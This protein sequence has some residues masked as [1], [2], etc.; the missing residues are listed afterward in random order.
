MNAADATRTYPH[1]IAHVHTDANGVTYKHL[2]ANGRAVHEHAS[3]GL[4]G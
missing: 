1:P 2:H 3:E 4:V